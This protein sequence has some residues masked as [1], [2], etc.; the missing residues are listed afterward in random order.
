MKIFKKL[1]V[2]S[3]ILLLPVAMFAG[4]G[5]DEMPSN[6]SATLTVWGNG[7]GEDKEYEM[8][9]ED[10]TAAYHILCQ[11]SEITEND[12]F[13]SIAWYRIDFADGGKYEFDDSCCNFSKLGSK[14]CFELT[15]EES[16]SLLEIASHYQ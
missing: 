4:C 1:M 6:L 8:T 7:S 10:A 5:N 13:E 2:L 3:M 11:Q 14:G 15:E 9:A 16:K 12:F